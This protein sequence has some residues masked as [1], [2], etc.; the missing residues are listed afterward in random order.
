MIVAMILLCWVL[1]PIPA[2]M[3]V[4]KLFA[5]QNIDSDVHEMTYKTERVSWPRRIVAQ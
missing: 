2:A 5:F 3:V 1:M 4:G